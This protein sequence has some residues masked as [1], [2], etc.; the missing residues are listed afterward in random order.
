MENVPLRS[1]QSETVMMERRD[2]GST[3]TPLLPR[4]PAGGG[5]SA[6]RL[7]LY[8]LMEPSHPRT[9]AERADA[10]DSEMLP[11]RTGWQRA[12]LV[13]ENCL[14]V[15]IL[16]NV[17]TFVLG[18]CDFTR[19]ADTPLCV[20]DPPPSPPTPATCQPVTPAG[21][22]RGSGPAALARTILLVGTLVRLQCMTPW[23][24]SR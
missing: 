4:S 20:R 17:F 14:V 8:D 2:S 18:T 11:E 7:C 16:V 1:T 3:Q 15:V 6:W 13:L 23:R 12:G 10:A 21:L 9:A 5:G 22:F 24:L 19:P